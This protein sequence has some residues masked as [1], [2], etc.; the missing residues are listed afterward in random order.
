MHAAEPPASAVSLQRG[1]C[2]AAP[3]GV[4][5][6]FP[7]E[8]AADPS[9]G[10]GPKGS[11]KLRPRTKPLTCSTSKSYAFR[12]NGSTVIVSTRFR[13]PAAGSTPH[14]RDDQLK[15]LNDQSVTPKNDVQQE[16]LN[17]G[18]QQGTP[19]IHRLGSPKL[20]A[21]N[22]LSDLYRGDTAK[23]IGQVESGDVVILITGP[24][25]QAGSTNMLQALTVA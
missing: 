12:E 23:H 4:C 1:V 17:Q 9:Q 11:R 13:T 22:T 24:S 5:K 7:P 8:T 20:N 14:R 2:C 19:E 16:A 15:G 10:D 25:R 21:R 6:Q 18:R 3:I